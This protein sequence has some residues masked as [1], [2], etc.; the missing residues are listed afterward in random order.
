[1]ERGILQTGPTELSL[2]G[3][4]HW[5][6]PSCNI[7]RYTLRTDGFV[8]AAAGYGGGELLT[9]PFIFAGE[10][11]EL[12]YSTSAV[13]SVRVEVQDAHGRPRQG[14]SLG[15]CP[16]MF[17]DEVE[18][19]VRWKGASDLSAQAG[20]P[21]RLRIVLKDADLYAF[22]FRPAGGEG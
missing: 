14:L 8:S 13:G 4:E 2:Y 18:G 6:L 17:G 19:V 21:V 3:M 15:D 12:N 20:R 9:R 11:L 7:R 1:M 10:E 16:Q 22:R 5:R